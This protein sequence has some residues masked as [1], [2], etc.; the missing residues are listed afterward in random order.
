MNG[1]LRAYLRS[2]GA[3]LEVDEGIA[4]LNVSRVTAQ[5]NEGNMNIE[6]TY[7]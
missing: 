6:I 1:S 7:V 4:A 3:E 5:L 2:G